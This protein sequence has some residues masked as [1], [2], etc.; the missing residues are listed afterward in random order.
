MIRRPPRSTRNDTLFP[1]TP[2]FRSATAEFPLA[3]GQ[4][5]TRISVDEQLRRGFGGSQP[6][7]IGLDAGDH[8][9]RLTINGN[10]PRPVERDAAIFRLRE[11]TQI[12]RAHV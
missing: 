6:T 4:N 1:Y 2:L 9:R 3:T 12:G 7:P 11:R 10:F 5:G 8:R